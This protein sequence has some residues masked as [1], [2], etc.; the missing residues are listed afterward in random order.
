MGSDDGQVMEVRIR[1]S[2]DVNWRGDATNHQRFAHEPYRIR[3]PTGSG[4]FDLVEI[5]GRSYD[6]CDLVQYAIA[7]ACLSFVFF[8]VY[9][10]GG[11]GGQG[12][13]KPT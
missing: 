12:S 9:S 2:P 10:I 11:G 13:L 6:P 8:I 3:E 7:F 5:G 1:S 4:L